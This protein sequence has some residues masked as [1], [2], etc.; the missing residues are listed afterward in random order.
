M[1]TAES[2]KR[3]RLTTPHTL[4]ETKRILLHHIAHVPILADTEVSFG[5]EATEDAPPV[6]LPRT[7]YG[8][9][10]RPK[11]EETSATYRVERYWKAARGLLRYPVTGLSG[12]LRK[13]SE[14]ETEVTVHVELYEMA[15]IVLG[16]ILIGILMIASP[17]T[18]ELGLIIAIALS[19]LFL[20]DAYVLFRVVVSIRD[21]TDP[22]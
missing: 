13:I 16:V 1:N 5:T 20:L 4:D 9:S 2:E 18:R 7:A 21:G 3:M 11:L 6:D 14:D 8:M 17:Q 15:Y 10:P 22:E 19:V 12:T